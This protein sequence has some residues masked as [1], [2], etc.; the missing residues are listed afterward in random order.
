[1][2]WKVREDSSKRRPCCLRKRLRKHKGAGV[3]SCAGRCLRK[4]RKRERN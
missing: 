2:D 1:M 3:V 4:E